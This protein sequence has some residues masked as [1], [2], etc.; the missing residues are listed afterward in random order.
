VHR[1]VRNVVSFPVAEAADRA[2]R[3]V[4]PKRGEGEVRR[5][6]LRQRR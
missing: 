4:L 6:R 3:N 1:Q 2:T 5:R